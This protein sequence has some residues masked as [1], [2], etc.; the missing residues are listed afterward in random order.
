MAQHDPHCPAV[1]SADMHPCEC[2]AEHTDAAA[3]DAFWEAE[4]HLGYFTAL[5]LASKRFDMTAAALEK[6]LI[7]D[8]ELNNGNC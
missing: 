3:V 1:A 8:D 2:G 6:L 5:G 7:A 4:T